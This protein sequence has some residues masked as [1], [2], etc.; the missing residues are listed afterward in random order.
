MFFL[1]ILRLVFTFRDEYQI[2]ERA[3]DWKTTVE[4]TEKTGDGGDLTKKK[5]TTI[6]WRYGILFMIL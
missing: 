1:V 4:E 3:I 2:R 6:S 5:D